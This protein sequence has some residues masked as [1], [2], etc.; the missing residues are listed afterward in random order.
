MKQRKLQIRKLKAR[1]EIYKDQYK[2]GERERERERGGGE[3]FHLFS[4]VYR[5]VKCKNEQKQISSQVA[6]S[7]QIVSWK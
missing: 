5:L 7:C 4:V 6:Y 2:E 1:K 3:V